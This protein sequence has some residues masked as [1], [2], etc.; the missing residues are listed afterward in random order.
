VNTPVSDVQ[1]QARTQSETG[2]KMNQTLRRL[3][4]LLALISTTL[5]FPFETAMTPYQQR[6]RD[7]L[8]SRP[9]S[10]HN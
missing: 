6:V 1:T 2:L 3:F 9:F 7:N 5:A 10:T 8:I 4:M